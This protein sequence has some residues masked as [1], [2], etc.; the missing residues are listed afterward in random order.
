MP[1]AWHGDTKFT[2][3]PSSVN[4]EDSLVYTARSRIDRK[5]VYVGQREGKIDFLEAGHRD[6]PPFFFSLLVLAGRVLLLPP[7]PSFPPSFTFTIKIL[8]TSSWKSLGKVAHA[9]NPALERQK[10][11]NVY[12]FQAT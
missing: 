10:Q 12:E 2:F 7:E 1:G 8:K 6:P 3:S 9:F 5:S 4:S 11:V